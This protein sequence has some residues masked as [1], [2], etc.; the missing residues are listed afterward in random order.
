ME[1]IVW[2][3]GPIKGKYMFELNTFLH[4][5]VNILKNIAVR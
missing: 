2:A 5:L 4:Y 1:D 3:L